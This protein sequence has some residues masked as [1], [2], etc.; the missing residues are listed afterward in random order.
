MKI[1][2]KQK[3]YYNL[4]KSS[5]TLGVGVGNAWDI[6]MLIYYIIM[7]NEEFID[8]IDQFKDGVIDLGTD[9]QRKGVGRTVR[10]AL[11]KE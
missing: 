4:I 7:N 11:E 6:G 1:L 9:V 8:E 3:K 2:N 10:G 5:S